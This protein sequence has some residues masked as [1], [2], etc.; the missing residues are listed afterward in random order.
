MP[1]AL[2]GRGAVVLDLYDGMPH[3]FQIR[4]EFADTPETKTAMKKMAA[5]LKRHLGN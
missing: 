5:F 2:A 4:P 1:T 3:V